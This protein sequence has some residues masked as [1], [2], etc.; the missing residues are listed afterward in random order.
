MNVAAP[1]FGAELARAGLAPLLRSTVAPLQVNVGKRCNQACHHCHVDA[2]PKRREQMDERTAE[3]VLTLLAA[4]PDIELLDLTGGASE[5]NPSFRSLVRGARQLGRRV[6][7]RCN[8]TILLQPGQEDTAEFLA[9]HGVEIV[10]SLPCYESENVERQ[11][12][13]GVY[14]QSIA[15]LRRLNSL[16][17]GGTGLVLDLVY[18][19]VGPFL[20]PAQAELEARYRDEL[21]RRHGIRFRRLLTIT[22]GGA[23]GSG[24]MGGGGLVTRV[25]P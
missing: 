19:P 10:A 11:R 16:G 20:P 14:A 21:G 9:A 8:L 5:L 23:G 12:G 1:C 25:V 6:I 2:G 13:R 22:R 4:N 17:Y 24:G 15:A 7:D 3:R 18:N